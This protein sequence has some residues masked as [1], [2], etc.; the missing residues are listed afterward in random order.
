MNLNVR[1]PQTG[2]MVAIKL[3]DNGDGSYSPVL[4]GGGS[5]SGNLTVTGS[6]TTPV[7]NAPTGRTASYVIAASN[8]SSLDKSQADAVCTGT[9]DDTIWTNAI[10]AGYKNISGTEGTYSFTSTVSVP[11]GVTINGQNAKFNNNNSTPLFSC[12]K[13][14]FLENVYTDYGGISNLINATFINVNI[15]PYPAVFCMGDSMT[16]GGYPQY[17]QT[18]LGI[19][20]IVNNEGISGNTT[21]QMLARFTADIINQ[22]NVSYCII[23]GGINDV[24]EGV[25]AATIESNL[26][27]MYT[28]AHNA[29]MMVVALNIS[30]F[31]TASWWTPGYQ[32]VA[33]AVNIW[34]ASTSVNVNYKINDFSVLVDPNNADQLLPAYDSGDGEHPNAAGYTAVA[35]AIYSGVTWIAGQYN[36]INMKGTFVSPQLVTNNITINGSLFTDPYSGSDYSG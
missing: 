27:S 21:T 22:G 13:G 34:I 9:N 20:W 28:A 25:S 36:S 29:G 2:E 31:K 17:L 1:D 10:S 14:C 5:V 8:S 35:S 15:D 30:P 23:W 32:A 7:L 3:V 6:I 16:A 24:N 12:A 33:D 4:V 19:G 26:Q 11:S 18:N